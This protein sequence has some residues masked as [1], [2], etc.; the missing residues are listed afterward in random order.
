MTL[1]ELLD[2]LKYRNVRLYLQ[3]GRLRCKSPPGALTPGL[4]AALQAYKAE[5]SI[6][7]SGIGRRRSPP[8]IPIERGK[9][10]PLSFAQQR[11]WFLDQLE[12]GNA[13]YNMFTAL[14][15]AGLLN[16]Q[17]L[18]KSFNELVCRHEVL[19][20]TFTTSG[21]DPAQVIHSKL[22]LSLPVVDLSGLPREECEAKIRCLATE[23]AGRPFDLLRGPL[24]RG[25][26]L[27]LGDRWGQSEHGLLLTMHHIVS[28][29]WS[30][31]LFFGELAALYE[32]FCAGQDSPLPPLPIQYADY[33][34]WQREWLQGE[35]LERQLSYW[36]EQLTGAPEVLAL[37]TDR[38]RPAAQSY[39]G[40]S[41]E[42]ML[43]AELTDQ[44]HALSRRE[45]VTR[46]MTLLA[47][48]N[49]VLHYETGQDDIVV[50]TDIANRNRKEI[51]GLVGFFVNQLVM[52]TNLS[53]DPTFSQLLG[54]TRHATLDAYAHQEL[55]FDKLVE[56]L[57]PRRNLALAPVFQI[58]MIL[59]NVTQS[60]IEMSGLAVTPIRIDRTTAELDLLLDV[61]ETEKGLNCSFE[62]N[63]DLF[64]EATIARYAAHVATVLRAVATDSNSTLKML[65]N[66]LAG[67]DSRRQRMEE[68]QLKAANY[69]KLANIQRKAV[70]GNV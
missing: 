16:V 46:F 64:G 35:E 28:D 18:E 36:K 6:R 8:I 52:R 41:Y 60:I 20:T 17:A 63:T 30:A 61:V 40:A 4:R 54:R 43:S 19:R 42:F 59:H 5:L 24:L 33:A 62:Y 55:P 58:K 22:G 31:A 51:E 39:R 25:T 50:G 26:L 10:L 48:F 13:V 7:V 14:R 34:V 29:D 49:V 44:L 23:E 65:K 27:R 21:G 11:L 38:P 12:P 47:A 69:R 15:I 2:E 3:N 1:P 66:K 68:E 53:D 9:L 45:E 67:N 70:N 32:A 37:P 56:I 57:R